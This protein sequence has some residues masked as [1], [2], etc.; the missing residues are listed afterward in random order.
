MRVVLTTRIFTPEP[1]AA[2]FR[3]QALVGALR[4]RGHEVTV[5]TTRAP[6]RV[7]ADEA[8]ARVSRWPVLRDSQGYVRGYLQYLSFDL[9]LVLRLLVQRADVV[10]VEPPP[11][12]GAVVRV[13]A[14]LRR[15]PYVYYAADVWSDAAAQA[16]SAGVVALLRRLEAWV[17]RGASA[18]VAVSDGVAERAQELGA[19]RVEVVRN[20]VD[21]TVFTPVGPT[22]ETVDGGGTAAPY[23]LYAGT[24]SEW[25][26]ADVFVRAMPRVLA[27]VPGARLVFVG[28]GSEWAHLRALAAELAPGAVELHGAVP[29]AEIARRLRGAT[30]AAVSIVPGQGYDFAYPTKVLAALACG[31]PVVYAGAGPATQDIATHHLGW[32]VA[33]DVDAVA[34]A[35]IAALTAPREDGEVAR[36]AAWVRE[37]RSIER[38]GRD[39]A[40]VVATVGREAT[41]SRRPPP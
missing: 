38:T 20:G 7:G 39:A 17:L 15:I 26:G 13:V 36:R 18:V 12:T 24:A 35:M 21:T 5:L 3:L 6:G 37:H 11:T 32:A 28:Q 23:L 29:P 2:S 8:G 30:G 16:G 22:A 27:A 31:V 33:Y 41:G 10:V 9:P 34:R 19:H 40:A 25:Q 1:A 14:G 4:G